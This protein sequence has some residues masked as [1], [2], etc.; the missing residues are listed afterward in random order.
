MP[1]Q[2]PKPALHEAILHAPA[3]HAAVAFGSE[4][5]V[6]HAPQS[7][8][9]L[10]TSVSQPFAAV[11]SQLRNEPLHA[12]EH[13]LPVHAGVAFA[14]VAQTFVQLPQCVASDARFVS[15]PFAALPSQSP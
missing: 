5:R 11:P 1:S 15:Q 8:A 2:S 9:E 4:Q 6:P 10:L 14:A 7:S 13:V 12:N 3:L